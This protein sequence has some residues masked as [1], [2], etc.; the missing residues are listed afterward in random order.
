MFEI[1]SFD[2]NYRDCVSEM[3][4]PVSTTKLV[5]MVSA[6]VI[7]HRSMGIIVI[8]DCHIRVIPTAMITVNA[9][10]PMETVPVILAG[11]VLAVKLQIAQEI[12][13]VEVFLTVFAMLPLVLPVAVVMMDGMEPAVKLHYA[14]VFLRAMGKAHV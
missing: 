13:P 6:S 14:L 5:R 3:R 1:L 4:V 8:N 2:L 12:R 7:I 9:I 10:S 11:L